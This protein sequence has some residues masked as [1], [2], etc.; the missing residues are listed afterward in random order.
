MYRKYSNRKTKLDGIC[1][2]SKKEAERYAELNLLQKSGAISNLRLQVPFE[3]L[4]KTKDERSVKYI[5]DFVYQTGE[6]TVVEDVKGYRTR[7]Y[8]LKRKLFK[9]RYPDVTF[10]EV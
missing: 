10:R 1:F 8:I 5:A 2:D 3:L 7:E 6:Q 9:Y 4:P